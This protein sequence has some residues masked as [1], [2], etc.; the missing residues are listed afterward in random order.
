MM[1]LKIICLAITVITCVV[2]IVCLVKST[3]NF[4]DRFYKKLG[5]YDDR[6]LEK[7][8]NGLYDYSDIQMEAQK[9]D[10]VFYL[11]LLKQF[12]I[13]LLLS[14]C[15]TITFFFGAHNFAKTTD[16]IPACMWSLLVIFFIVLLILM[17]I[18]I[19]KA[20]KLN[21]RYIPKYSPGLGGVIV[22]ADLILYLSLCISL[23]LGTG[24]GIIP[25][26]LGL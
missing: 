20:K 22:P 8:K 7:Y 5:N 21:I 13:S 17:V 12:L 24:I 11:M 23:S 16:Y 19:K 3:K 9:R 14:V 25:I 26:I 10:D 1:V 6:K 15:G 4:S 18:Y 2:N